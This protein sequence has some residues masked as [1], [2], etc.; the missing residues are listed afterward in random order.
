MRCRLTA[1]PTSCAA[2]RASRYSS[3]WSS[4]GTTTWSVKRSL[5]VQVQPGECEAEH[6][7]PL[8][9]RG[10]RQL[11]RQPPRQQPELLEERARVPRVHGEPV[12]PD[13]RREQR[14]QLVDGP[15]ADHE[16]VA[17]F[18]AD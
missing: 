6:L 8:G 14:A 2:C 5:V 1:S 11:E 17:E 10:G 9:R 3:R 7:R 12:L 13:R 18:T 15:G 4:S 16:M